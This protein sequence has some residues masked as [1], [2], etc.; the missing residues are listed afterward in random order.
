[1]PEPVEGSRTYFP[2]LDGIRAIAVLGVIAFHVGAGWAAGGLLGVGVFFVLSGYLITDLLVAEYRRRHKIDLRRFWIRRARRLLPAL[3]LMLFVVIGWATLFDRVQLGALRDDLPSAIAY[4]SN[5]WFIYQHVSY[6]ARFGPP[7]PFGHLWSL[8]IEEQ[9]YLLWPLLLLAGLRLA[10]HRR[11]LIAIVLAAAAGSAIEMALLYVPFGDPTRVYD[12]TDTRAFALLIGAALALAWPRDLRIAELTDGARRVLEIAGTVALGGIVVLFGATSEY[13]AFLYRGGMVL[14]A[15]LSAV[16][17]A[18]TIHP[19]TRFARL[20]GIAP[21]RW[22]GKRSYGI[23]LWSYPVIVLTTP[24]NKTPGALRSVIDIAISFALAALSW[25]F[26]EEPIRHGALEGFW[27]RA[28]TWTFP[29]PSHKGWLLGSFATANV[30]VCILGLSGLVAGPSATP[31]SSVTAILPTGPGSSGTTSTTQPNSSAGSGSTTV[32]AST[33]PLPPK[34]AG[35]LAIGDSIMIDAAPYLRQLLPGIAI[36]A[37]EGQ[38]LYQVQAAVAKLR[39]QKVIG[40]RLIL[41]LGTN[42]PY[43]KIALNN[44]IRSFGPMRKIVLVN[45]YVSRPWE[46]LVNQTI[47]AVAKLHPNVTV[48]NW[49]ALGPRHPGFFYPDGIHLN[50]TGAHYYAGLIAAAIQVPVKVAPT[51]PPTLTKL[52]SCVRTTVVQPSSFIISC[53]DGYIELTKAHWTS[54]SQSVASGTTDF[55]MNRCVPSC[56]AS[57]MTFF[58]HSRVRLSR[59]ITTKFGSVFSSLVVHYKLAGREKTFSFSWKSDAT[60]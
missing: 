58:P 26:I 39:E 53:A 22:I 47:A 8:A 19:G 27:R 9:F 34:G 56:A 51:T 20:L 49:F 11:L 2:G 28:R 52:L 43:S 40:D 36:D 18:V 46:Q 24:G 23:Y 33:A 1:M 31:Q 38:Q 10:R 12:G 50:P 60:I 6:F 44:L 35:I 16:L 5:W 15:L 13:E 21:L 14:C 59:P 42:G 57:P 54:W 17:I 25:N 41:E 45:S 7:T 3:F 4:Y 37:I 30:V 32:T 48:V 55:G 29:R